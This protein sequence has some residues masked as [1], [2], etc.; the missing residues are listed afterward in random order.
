MH[1]TQ[2]LGNPAGHR[3]SAPHPQPHPLS[4][5]TFSCA[6]SPG[7]CCAASQRRPVL[8]GTS[9]PM[10]TWILRRVSAVGDH[11]T[12]P[13]SGDTKSLS[14]QRKDICQERTT[15]ACWMCPYKF[16]PLGHLHRV[17]NRER[18]ALYLKQPL[19]R[20]QT[21]PKVSRKKEIIKIRGRI[22]MK[23][24]SNQ[25]KARSLRRQAKWINLS[26]DSSRNTVRGFKSRKL[27]M[28]EEKLQ[29]ET[30]EIQQGK[31]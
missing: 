26:P 21:K 29:T 18:S 1:R 11:L 22:I 10:L 31:E 5:P 25:M 17:S 12:I 14:E 27:E 9:H 4:S 7:L 24:H 19:R 15:G 13:V 20:G 30:T 6:S 16:K 8:K 2:A 3:Y 28:K 23:K